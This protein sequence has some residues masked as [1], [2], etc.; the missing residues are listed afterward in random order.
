[1][2][3]FFALFLAVLCLVFGACAEENAADS[4]L[5][6][7]GVSFQRIQG[8]KKQVPEKVEVKYDV[9]ASGCFIARHEIGYDRQGRIRKWN[10]YDVEGKIYLSKEYQYGKHTIETKRQDGNITIKVMDENENVLKC[11]WFSDK[12]RKHSI[13][14]LYDS[15]NRE[16]KATGYDENGNVSSLAESIY[17]DTLTYPA[18]KNIK[19]KDGYTTYTYD[20]KGNQLSCSSCVNGK[21]EKSEYKYNAQNEHTEIVRVSGDKTERTEYQYDENGNCILRIKYEG[22]TVT[23]RREYQYDEAGN[24][25]LSIYD[26]DLKNKNTKTCKCYTP[27][28]TLAEERYFEENELCGYAQYL[29]TEN[30]KTVIRYNKEGEIGSKDV[31]E[32]DDMG[33]E[34]KFSFYGYEGDSLV[35]WR[36]TDYYSDGQ[37][38]K[39]IEYYENGEERSHYYKDRF[40]NTISFVTGPNDPF[41]TNIG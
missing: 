2:K 12:D 34:I 37:L 35:W 10:S 20:E 6:I 33:R 5:G 22:N 13:D 23:E 38:A 29:Y 27:E 19:F 40:G 25:I 16:I 36:E 21:T 39:S 28:G 7:S 15:Q 9:D 11:I 24:C 31:Y 14:Y 30:S 26:D 3:K 17:E 32:Y 8:L 1:M 41:V 4:F 18:V